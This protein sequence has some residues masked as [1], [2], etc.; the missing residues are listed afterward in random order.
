M[1]DFEKHNELVNEK[2]INL[3]TNKSSGVDNIH[4]R[5]SKEPSNEKRVFNTVI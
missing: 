4:L 1:K 3:K 2:L 5:I